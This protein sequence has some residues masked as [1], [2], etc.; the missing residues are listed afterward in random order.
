MDDYFMGFVPEP[1]TAALL[2]CG[3]TILSAFRHR[4]TR[5]A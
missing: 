4:L 2:A 1:S 3:L 5:R